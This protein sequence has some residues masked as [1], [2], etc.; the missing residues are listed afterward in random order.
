MKTTVSNFVFTFTSSF[1]Y[2]PMGS[3]LPTHTSN[4]CSSRGDTRLIRTKGSVCLLLTLQWL[5][6]HHFIYGILSTSLR[7]YIQR[8]FVDRVYDGMGFI[9]H[10]QSCFDHLYLNTNMSYLHF[11]WLASVWSLSFK[12]LPL[13]TPSILQSD[14]YSWK[15]WQPRYH[16]YQSSSFIDPSMVVPT[17]YSQRWNTRCEVQPHHTI[18]GC[19]RRQ[20]IC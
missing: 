19:Q 2:Q 1:L 15:Q 16:W 18:L 14:C 5:L 13:V 6:E 8:R 11:C 10:S 7:Q 3:L 4:L 12:R 17:W 9:Y 20:V